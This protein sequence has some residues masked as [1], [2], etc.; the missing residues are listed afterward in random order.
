MCFKAGANLAA[1]E[2]GSDYII[3]RI[4]FIIYTRGEIDRSR[5]SNNSSNDPS[6]LSGFD[7]DLY[8]NPG[9]Q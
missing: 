5:P 4:I 8:I 1:G 7:L 3:R 2:L 6:M 9:D